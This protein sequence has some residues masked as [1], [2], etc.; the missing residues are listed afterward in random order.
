MRTG[1]ED[2][3][4]ASLRATDE[5][6]AAQHTSTFFKKRIK[7]IRSQ[8]I[9]Q[10]WRKRFLGRRGVAINEL[11]FLSACCSFRLLRF[12]GGSDEHQKGC[13]RG[14]TEAK[15]GGEEDTL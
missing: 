12:V 5:A 11:L 8:G 1:R 7:R 2:V 15:R 6:Q 10:E 4:F 14:R 3:D 13:R 9:R